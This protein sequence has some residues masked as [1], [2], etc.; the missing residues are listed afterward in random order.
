MD[1]AYKG[2]ESSKDR[3][4]DI[5]LADKKYDE[6]ARARADQEK[7]DMFSVLTQVFLGIG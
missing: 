1:Y 2:A 7:S 5:V 3:V 4:L 6:Y